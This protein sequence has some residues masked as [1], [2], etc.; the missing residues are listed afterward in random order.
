MRYWPRSDS[1]SAVDLAAASVDSLK[2]KSSGRYHW[3]LTKNLILV[4][5]VR[6]NT[7]QKLGATG[8]MIKRETV[9]GCK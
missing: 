9:A 6:N 8:R 1:D 5:L 3:Y 2:F 7:H 4:T